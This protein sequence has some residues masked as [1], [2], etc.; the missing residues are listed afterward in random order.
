MIETKKR[1]G[2]AEVKEKFTKAG[3]KGITITDLLMEFPEASE[4]NLRMHVYK[5][6]EEQSVVA[7]DDKR[8]GK[9]VYVATQSLKSGPVEN[10]PKENNKE[11]PKSVLPTNIKEKTTTKMEDNTT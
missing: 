4:A 5:L 10:E 3:A 6:T 11:A 9:K 8:D 7:T 2:A 1:L